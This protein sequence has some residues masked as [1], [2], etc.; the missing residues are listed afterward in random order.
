MDER[1]HSHCHRQ[2]VEKYTVE[3]QAMVQFGQ[4]VTLT[5]KQKTKYT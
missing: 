1:Q 5:E 4:K 2:A 3:K